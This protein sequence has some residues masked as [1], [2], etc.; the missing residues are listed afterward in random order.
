MH[1]QNLRVKVNRSSP[2]TK[3]K[4]VQPK[5][6]FGHS[7]RKVELSI[8]TPTP[9]EKSNMELTDEKEKK[10]EAPIK[11]PTR[12]EKQTSNRLENEEDSSP[13]N[14]ERMSV[15]KQREFGRQKK[16]SLADIARAQSTRDWASWGSPGQQKRV[17]PVD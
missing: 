7:T 1:K 10:S 15:G 17:T 13:E 12:T 11:T 9:Q 8:E 5:L 4:K 14:R 2:Q 16:K 6:Q 3:E